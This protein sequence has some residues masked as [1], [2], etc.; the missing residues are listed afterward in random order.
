MREYYPGASVRFLFTAA[1]LPS[2]PSVGYPVRQPYTPAS[3]ALVLQQAAGYGSQTISVTASIIIDGQGEGH[4]DT[5]LP[6]TISPG[7][8]CAI[9]QATGPTASDNAVAQER[10][11]VLPLGQ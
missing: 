3:L 9:L 4:A 6:L 11:R 2:P 5:V 7:P 10:F 8:W 1:A